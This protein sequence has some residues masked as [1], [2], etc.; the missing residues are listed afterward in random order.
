MLLKLRR[1]LLL[2]EPR[3]RREL[4]REFRLKR[5]VIQ[6]ADWPAGST[7]PRANAPWERQRVTRSS[8]RLLLEG[9]GSQRQIANKKM[10][11]QQDRN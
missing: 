10:I 2:L 3:S 7:G 9:P 1:R 5:R 11:L 6:P 4:T 8:M